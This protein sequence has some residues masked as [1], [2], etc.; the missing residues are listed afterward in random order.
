MKK[1]ITFAALAFITAS[2]APA[3]AHDDDSEVYVN[4]DY[5]DSH[6]GSDLYNGYGG[7][8]SGLYSGYAGYGSGLY[9]GYGSGSY[10]GYGGYYPTNSWGNSNHAL[11]AQ[12]HASAAWQHA[13]QD[14]MYAS[15]EHAAAAV[16]HAIRDTRHAQRDT[17]G[18]GG[19][20]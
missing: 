17:Y 4:P 7:H 8:G 2:A 18:Y 11:Q 5:T 14:L 16:R 15:P 13:Q 20:Y 3:F 12:G 19:W 1:I 6:Y 9:G 10:S